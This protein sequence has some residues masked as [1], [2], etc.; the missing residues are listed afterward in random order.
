MLKAK[1]AYLEA[2]FDLVYKDEILNDKEIADGSILCETLVSAISPGTE[3]AAYTGSAPLRP[4]K[5]YPR[6][7]GYCNV[8]MVMECG[9]AVSGIKKGDKVLT[10]SSHR[11]HFIV[12]E[13]EILAVIPDEI[14]NNLAAT[15]YLYHLGY[16]A[17]L[18]S[19]LRYGSPTVVIGLG[20]IGLGAVKVAALAGADVYAIS[21]HS[22]LAEIAM[23]SGAKQVFKRDQIDELKALL[24]DRL[25]DVVITT[26]NSW[27]DWRSS[28]ELAGVNAQI[29]V[30][31]FPG[32][33]IDQIPFNPL[34]SQFFYMKQLRIQAV[35]MAPENN[36]SRQF[37]KFNE[38]NNLKFLLQQI[39][40]RVLD[41]N[42]IISGE[43]SWNDLEQAY[44][45]L[46]SRINS[47][48]TYT[49]RWKDE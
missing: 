24:G 20:A 23:H 48:I 40:S 13:S 1:I 37:L 26:T 29:S 36:D 22:H 8:A 12:S 33:D 38:K 15:V 49:L 43:Y 25:A 35:G 34:D 7:V 18:K 30:L 14:P 2:P 41:P 16:D 39:Q 32:R 6:L 31:G 28:L 10:F 27:S 45:S 11:S 46:N 17:I 47:P 4:G 21:D 42:Y 5:V 9:T 44:D 19:E 3:L